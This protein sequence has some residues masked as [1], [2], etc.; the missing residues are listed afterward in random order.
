MDEFPVVAECKKIILRRRILNVAKNKGIPFGTCNNDVI[1]LAK[2]IYFHSERE[3]T[4][5]EL[6]MMLVER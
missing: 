1:L 6:F 2:Y 3:L 5:D 4:D